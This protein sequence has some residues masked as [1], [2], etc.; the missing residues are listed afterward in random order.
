[1]R[2]SDDKKTQLDIISGGLR[3]GYARVSTV[4]QNLDLQRDA[5]E[6][7][8]CAQTYEEKASGRAA[9]GRPELENLRRALRRGDT[10]VVWRLDRLGRSMPELV[11]IVTEL[12]EQGVEFESITEQI[13]TSTPHGRMFFGFMAVMAQYTR[14]VIHENTMAGLKAARARGR[15]GGRKHAL[16]ELGIKKARAMLADPDIT[17]ASVAEQ[18][19]VSRA[20][21]YNTLKR[22]DQGKEKATKAGGR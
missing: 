12:A 13:N 3:I 6:R 7:A 21:L 11:Q 10:L 20:T 2:H 5:L 15:V 4:D 17:V 18:L 8:G 9:K 19:G 1:M 14:E 22:D 16:D